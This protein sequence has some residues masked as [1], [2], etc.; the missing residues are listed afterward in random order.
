MYIYILSHPWELMLALCCLFSTSTTSATGLKVMPAGAGG[1]E[2][3]GGAEG[4]EGGEGGSGRDGVAGARPFRAETFQGGNS[5][6]YA[7]AILETVTDL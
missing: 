3:A 7:A 6:K 5:V 1:V 2:G 4:G